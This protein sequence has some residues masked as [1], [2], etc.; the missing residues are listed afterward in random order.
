LKQETGLEAKELELLGSYWSG[1]GST[2][3]EASIFLARGLTQGQAEPE[4]GEFF[5][6]ERYSFD[7]IAEMIDNHTIRDA[8]SIVAFHFLEQH[9]KKL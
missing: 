1:V 5:D 9:L 4:E 8:H 6:I 7:E 3:Q 2:N